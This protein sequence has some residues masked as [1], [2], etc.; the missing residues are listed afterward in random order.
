MQDDAARLQRHAGHLVLQAR[1]RQAAI[2][3]TADAIG[4]AVG[5][6]EHLQGIGGKAGGALEAGVQDPRMAAAL[7]KILPAHDDRAKSRCL[8]NMMIDVLRG[9]GLVVHEKAA[10]REAKVLHQDGI[11]RQ[12]VPHARW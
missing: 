4:V 10:V 12:I 2:A 6:S 1:V 7:G 9:V 8:R 11:G 3:V 5:R